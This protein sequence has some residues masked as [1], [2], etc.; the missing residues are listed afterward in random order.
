VSSRSGLPR[1]WFSA[2]AVSVNGNGNAR[3]APTAAAIRSTA[4][5]RS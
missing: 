1:M 5:E 2:R 3:A 4:C